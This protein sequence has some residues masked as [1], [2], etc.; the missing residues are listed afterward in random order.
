MSENRSAKRMSYDRVEDWEERLEAAHDDLRT[1]L[2]DYVEDPLLHARRMRDLLD[3]LVRE[4]EAD[5]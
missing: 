3:K 4:L 5:G 1:A 2:R